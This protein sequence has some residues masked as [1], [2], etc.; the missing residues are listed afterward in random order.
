VFCGDVGLCCCTCTDLQK[1]LELAVHHALAVVSLAY[2]TCEKGLPHALCSFHFDTYLFTSLYHYSACRM[3]GSPQGLAA[4]CHAAI[5]RWH[6]GRV[7]R[8]I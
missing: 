4:V 8:S 3:L 7:R 2:F 5:S 6:A 1:D